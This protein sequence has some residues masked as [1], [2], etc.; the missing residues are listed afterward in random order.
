MLSQAPEKKNPPKS[1]CYTILC[2][3]G[4]RF[5]LYSLLSWEPQKPIQI[6]PHSVTWCH[7]GPVGKAEM[8]PALRNL[9][10]LIP[11]SGHLLN[12]IIGLAQDWLPGIL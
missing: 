6:L 3:P 10:V 4:I 8:W 12:P 11:L 5:S 1:A 7:F 2:E 9:L